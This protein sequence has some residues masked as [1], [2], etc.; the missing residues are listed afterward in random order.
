MNAAT[1]PAV[2]APEIEG[3]VQVLENRW[4]MAHPPTLPLVIADATQYRAAAAELAEAKRLAR[5]IEQKR[6]ELTRPVDALKGN[7]KA[8]FDKLKAR[9]DAIVR[10]IDLA[11]NSYD[12][13]QRQAAA[14]AQRELEE[15]AER[16]R[17]F[18][19]QR[20]ARAVERGEHEKAA[21]IAAAP[22][23]PVPVVAAKIPDVKGAPKREVWEFEVTDAKLL[24]PEY[25]MPDV[26]KIGGVVRSL[27]KVDPIP[28]VRAW[29]KTVRY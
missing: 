12:E 8:F 17:R 16:E 2:A 4:N 28:G 24:P 29:P 13:R 18:N 22:P 25:L 14:K 20:A 23:A 19:E 6:L 26:S 11:L 5:A 15:A 27:K 1:L 7:I 9:P 10:R 3:Q 21:E